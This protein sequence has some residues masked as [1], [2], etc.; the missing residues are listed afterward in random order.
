MRVNEPTTP[1]RVYGVDFSGAKDA[2]RRIWVSCGVM[3]DGRL[4]IESCLRC[5]EIP[6]SGR[7]RVRC[8]AALLELIDRE[9]ATA[10]FG[11]D[12]P[13]G[14]PRRH[15]RAGTS[16]QQFVRSFPDEYVA[17]EAFRRACHDRAGGKESKRATDELSH[18]PF[19]PYNLRLFRQTFYG[20]RDLLHPL[21]CYGRARV[22]PMQPGPPGRP[23]VLEI[24][25]ASTLKD[26]GLPGSGY[27]RSGP[28]GA[29]VRAAILQGIEQTG[30]IEFVS[31]GVRARSLE[32]PGGDALDSVIAAMATVRAL[33]APTP[34]PADLRAD[35]MLEGYVYI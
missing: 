20:I 17:P 28:A 30:L 22:L 26:L 24:C 12:F 18:T 21:V 25:P 15:L 35:Y 4:R 31:A 5:D 19:S 34:Q 10:A 2:G 3:E 6:G 1:N 9:T 33:A 7:E 23:W 13:F 8:L 14:L 32:D 11:L 16:W 27:K 29:E